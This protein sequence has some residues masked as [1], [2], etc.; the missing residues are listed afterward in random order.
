MNATEYSLFDYL[1]IL[2]RRWLWSL[3]PVVL[4]VAAAYLYSTTRA[5]RYVASANVLL[6]DSAAQRTLDPSSGNTGSLSNEI[7]LARSDA[8]EQLVVEELGDLPDIAIS[9]VSQA[10]V[11]TFTAESDDPDRA[12]L[13]ANIWAESYVEVKRDEVVA[14]IATAIERLQSRL[15]EIRTERQN[16]RQPLDDLQAEITDA[17]PEDAPALQAQYDR[18]AD[19]L[20]YEL[21]LLT[22]QSQATLASLANLELQAELS[23]LGTARIVQVANPPQE[24]RNPPLSRDL[25]LG[26]TV[27]LLAGF[28]LALLADTRQ[29]HQVVGRCRDRYRSAGSGRHPRCRE[30]VQRR[31]GPGHLG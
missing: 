27:G 24:R 10:D 13:V 22:A 30:Q 14:S 11:L 19:D 25:A 5:D 4:L 31:T 7:S 1:T 26:A 2:R 16:L 17:T 9:S 23:T 21:D 12:A 20:S 28:G 18:L 15:E 8:V 3:I 29:H 6:A